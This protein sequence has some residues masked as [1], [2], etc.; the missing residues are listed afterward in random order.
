MLL[1]IVPLSY[2]IGPLDM[3]NMDSEWDWL[4]D[5]FYTDEL[6]F[7]ILSPFYFL[8]LCYLLNKKVAIRK[9]LMIMLICSSG[10]YSF[11]CFMLL[12]MPIPDYVPFWGTLLILLFFPMLIVYFFFENKAIKNPNF[13]IHSDALLDDK[14]L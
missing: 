14:V 7:I 10:F 5:Y 6:M 1:F 2:S 8:W 11:I 4:P 3:D 12:S 9:A 13:E